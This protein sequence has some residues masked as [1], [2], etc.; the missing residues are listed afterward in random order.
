MES[1][2][3]NGLSAGNLLV[4]GGTGFLGNA[5]VNEAIKRDYK[6]FVLCRSKPELSKRHE[7]VTYLKADIARYKDVKLQIL[8]QNINYVVNLCGDI[9]HV[10]YRSGG[11]EVIDAHLQGIF[12]VI[13][14][15]NWESLKC[16]VQVGSSDEYGDAIAP[17]REDMACSSMASYSFAK[18][19]ATNFMKMLNN[20]ELF[21]GIILRPFLVYGPGQSKN[22]FL[23]QVINACLKGLPFKTTYGN[24]LRDFCYV[25]DFINGVFSA[26]QSKGCFGEVINLASGIPVSIRSVIQEVIKL[27]GGGEPQYG[28]IKYKP[29]ENMALY[30]DIEKAKKMLNWNPIT[31]FN[32]GLNKTIE[33]YKK[34]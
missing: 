31:E 12:N 6:V 33:Y 7:G 9:S 27:V 17:Q 3:K 23:P 1:L 29:F 32:E 26:L 19:S 11:A 30:A 2:K 20:T 8:N 15:I 18:N 14:C 13:R 5:L 4:L 16:F 22:R 25:G 28:A 24:Q 21:P 34:I 10:K